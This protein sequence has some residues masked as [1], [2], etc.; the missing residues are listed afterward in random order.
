MKTAAYYILTDNSPALVK[1]KSAIQKVSNNITLHQISLTQFREAKL[2]PDA[3][4]FV[5]HIYL[6]TDL[7]KLQEIENVNWVLL[8]NEVMFHYRILS[9]P[10]I[11]YI[12][13]GLPT[14]IVKSMVE[15]IIG[16]RNNL[17]N[18]S[19]L[20][21]RI[22][23]FDM[24]RN[25]IFQS[26]PDILRIESFGDYSKIFVLQENSKVKC[27]SVSHNL[28]YVEQKLVKHPFFRIH[29]SHI[30]NLS[31]LYKEQS[32]ND[33]LLVLKGGVKIPI[34]RRRKKPLLDQIQTLINS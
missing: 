29:R 32:F 18:T 2:N 7:V 20:N 1:I 17:T 6:M 33:N 3:V 9:N 14:T 8:S 27:Y 24:H 15:K 28:K 30:V 31:H 10:P 11:E 4:L 12:N 34:A 22:E 16:R 13:L 21:D 19:M 26:I 5:D 23:L 25:C